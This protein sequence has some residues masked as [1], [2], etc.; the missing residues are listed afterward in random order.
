[1]AERPDKRIHSRSEVLIGMQE[2]LSGQ[3]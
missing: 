2:L 3:I 1:M